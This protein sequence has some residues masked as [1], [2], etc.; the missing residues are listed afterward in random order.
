MTSS[1]CDS[2][3]ATIG[4]P[5]SPRPMKPQAGAGCGPGGWV[6]TSGRLVK[7]LVVDR[8]GARGDRVVLDVREA[9]GAEVLPEDDAGVH[10]VALRSS[11][12]PDASEVALAFGGVELVVLALVAEHVPALA[13]DDL[14]VVDGQV[15]VEA[16][17][18]L[19]SWVAAERIVALSRRQ[20]RTSSRRCSVAAASTDSPSGARTTP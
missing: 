19:T 3:L 1:P 10:E 15:L 20:R 6:L 16:H 4:S 13:A 2:R 18:A 9:A 5:I 14:V 7:L 11:Q 17:Q 8:G 12:Q